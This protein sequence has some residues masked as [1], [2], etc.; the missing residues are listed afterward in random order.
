MSFDLIAPNRDGK[1]RLQAQIPE[2]FPIILKF[3]ATYEA[4]LSLKTEMEGGT[5]KTAL[6]EF[7][8][9]L[10][11]NGGELELGLCS[12]TSFPTQK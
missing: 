1:G 11:E 6:E 4:K 8:K 3:E 2:V 9:L 12:I 7:V 5:P 10:L